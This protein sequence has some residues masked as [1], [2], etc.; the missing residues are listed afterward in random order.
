MN[1]RNSQVR[2]GLLLAIYLCSLLYPQ[3][4]TPPELAF[5]GEINSSLPAF[6]KS[7][8]AVLFSANQA[9]EKKTSDVRIAGNS[10]IIKAQI[11]DS[12]KYENQRDYSVNN[13]LHYNLP[14]VLNKY[15]VKAHTSDG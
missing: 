2:F 14:I 11:V 13:D 6:L 8:E 10:D 1:T 4:M 5:H 15:P 3:N 7:N 9:A 12:P